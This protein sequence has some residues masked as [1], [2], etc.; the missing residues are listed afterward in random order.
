MKRNFV[1][2]QKIR[3]YVPRKPYVLSKM[4]KKAIR[5][6]YVLSKKIQRK[7]KENQ[8]SGIFCVYD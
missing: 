2:F 6:Y 7:L 3:L 8:E 4:H 5:L 1:S